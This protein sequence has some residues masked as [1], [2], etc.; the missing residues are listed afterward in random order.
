MNNVLSS[1]FAAIFSRNPFK[2]LSEEIYASQVRAGEQHAS[3][4]EVINDERTLPRVIIAW[5]ERA[6]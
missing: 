6:W 2:P 3:P 4:K 1:F 5:K